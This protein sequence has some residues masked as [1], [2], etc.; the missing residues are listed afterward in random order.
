MS[1]QTSDTTHPA[2]VARTRT[3]ECG[4][5]SMARSLAIAA[6]VAILGPVVRAAPLPAGETLGS[7]RCWRRPLWS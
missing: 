3:A 4:E 2:V 5:R 6:G 7:L 1:G